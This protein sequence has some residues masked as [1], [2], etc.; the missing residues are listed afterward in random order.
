MSTTVK[1]YRKINKTK[2]SK[3]KD[4]FNIS[5]FLL[6]AERDLQAI[7]IDAF[8]HPDPW[9]R[10]LSLRV[11]LLIIHERDISK[12]A[13]GNK[14]REIYN[15]LDIDDGLKMKIISSLR[16][17]NKVHAKVKKQLSEIRNST[18]AHRDGDSMLQYD[19]IEKLSINQ[20]KELVTEYYEA[21]NDFMGLLTQLLLEAS[22]LKSM[23][24][25]YSNA[26][27]SVEK[28]G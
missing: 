15:Q 8:S 17:I 5:L 10:N 7:K 18:I 24:H 2:L 23:I 22:T 11:M 26:N 4:I 12:V 21:S 3:T 6:L 1:E 13:S 19:V 9:K 28:A 16:E 25:Q 14:M 27:S 20:I